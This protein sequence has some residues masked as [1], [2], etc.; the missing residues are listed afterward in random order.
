MNETEVACGL[1]GARGGAGQAAPLLARKR[2]IADSISL[3]LLREKQREGER[4]RWGGTGRK[5][6]RREERRGEREERKDREKEEEEDKKKR[7][8]SNF[9]GEK[10]DY[11]GNRIG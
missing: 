7:R 9:R 6:E 5:R 4:G 10:G 1:L 8:R 2:M 3:L 11:Q